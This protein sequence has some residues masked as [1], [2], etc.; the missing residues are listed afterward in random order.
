M[1]LRKYKPVTAG[2]RWRIGNAYAEI[3]TNVPEKS[4]LEKQKSTAGRNAQGRRSMRY[5]GG[6]NKNM[7][8]IIDFKRDKKN[9]PAVVKTI[10]YDPNRT[11]F[12][13][14][15]NYADGEKRYILAPN[16]IQVGQTIE[17]G[18]NVAPEL[19]NALMLRNIPLGTII[20]NIEMQPGKGGMIARSAGSWAQL[21]AKE[22]KYVIV[23]MPSGETRMILDTCFATVGT[24]SNPDHNL[25][26]LGKAG[27]NRWLGVRPRN[28]GVAMNPVDHPMGGGEGRSSGGHPRSRNGKYSKGMKTRHPKKTTSKFIITRRKK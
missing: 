8:R 23:R 11:A 2:T 21:S 22:G 28:R 24:V 1:A 17:A 9:I 14:L 27:R 25:Q 16:G 3:T 7:Y 19:G 4:L 6:G 12:I 18:E 13:A 26:Q 5:I 10:E 20:H 15:V